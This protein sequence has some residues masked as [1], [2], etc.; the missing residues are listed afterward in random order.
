MC[1][2][3]QLVNLVFFIAPTKAHF[4]VLRGTVRVRRRARSTTTA[5]VKGGLCAAAVVFGTWAH[6]SFAVVLV[7]AARL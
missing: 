2:R 6:M 3:S 7:D 1:P 5:G 4:V